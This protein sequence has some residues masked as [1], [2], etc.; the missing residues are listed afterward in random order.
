MVLEETNNECD[1]NPPRSIQVE[2]IGSLEITSE[3]QP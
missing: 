1:N 2:N 3:L